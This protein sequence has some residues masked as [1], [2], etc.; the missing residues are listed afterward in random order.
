MSENAKTQLDPKTCYE[1]LKARDRRYDGRFFVGVLSTG[2]YCRPICPAKTP[3]FKNIRFCRTASEAEEQG[4]RP[5]KRCRPETAADSP[6]HQG[7]TTTV[8]R[9]LKMIREGYLLE[10]SLEDLAATLG[11]SDRHLRGLFVKELGVGPKSIELSRRLDFAKNMIDHT[12]LKMTEIAFHA[13]FSSLRRFNDAVKKR[14]SMSPTQLRGEKSSAGGNIFYLSYRPPYDW[15]AFLEFL[16]G[17]AIG[18]V[19]CIEGDTYW[20][21]FDLAGESGWLKVSHEPKFSRLVLETSTNDFPALKLVDRIKKM[22]DIYADPL[23]IQESLSKSRYLKKIVHDNEGLRIPGAWDGFEVAVRAVLGQLISVVA[24]ST[25]CSRI[26]ERYGTPV[27]IDHPD[28][29]LVFPKPKTLMRAKL[30]ELG[31]TAGKEKAIQELARLAEKES[32]FEKIEDVESFKQ[33]LLEVRGIGPWTVEY[34]TLRL[35]ET[36]AF[37]A[38]DLIVKRQ[39]EKLAKDKKKQKEIVSQWQPWR[40]YA[41][42]YLWKDYAKHHS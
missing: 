41:A 18:G 7:T 19:E 38:T 8:R 34:M 30:R 2:I 40:S 20:R 9:A 31:V 14:Y 16:R 29:R 24:A 32:F 6:I 10:R 26:V 37:P 1:V 17:R 3:L 23:F 15:E 36:N 42:L 13:G 12:S 4:L 25:I 21:T 35:S 33:R 27:E 5:C 28:L 39:L 11:V 22:F